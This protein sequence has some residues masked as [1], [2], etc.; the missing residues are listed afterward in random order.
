MEVQ[1]EKHMRGSCSDLSAALCYSILPVSFGFVPYNN[2][3]T[4]NASKRSSGYHITGT[5]QFVM[6][7][8][9]T[10]AHTRKASLCNA[11]VKPVQVTS[12][13]LAG[14][15]SRCKSYVR[16]LSHHSFDGK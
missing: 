3:R 5:L 2:Q 14:K 7:G 15:S 11:A 10:H 16:P 4:V 9:W 6:V 1:E 13:V 8:G 12:I